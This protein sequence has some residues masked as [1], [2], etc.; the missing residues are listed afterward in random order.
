MLVLFQVH[1]VHFRRVHVAPQQEVND[2]H[3][4]P[5]QAVTETDEQEE[6]QAQPK[7]DHPRTEFIPP[8]QLVVIIGHV[9]AIEP[10]VA[11]VSI[12]VNLAVDDQWVAVNR[13]ILQQ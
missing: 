12:L 6:E 2:R 5:K 4:A 11:V 9:L 7:G 3:Q 8:S 13:L 10:E 1:F